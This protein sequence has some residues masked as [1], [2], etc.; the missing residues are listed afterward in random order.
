MCTFG[1]SYCNHH[2]QSIL[3]FLLGLDYTTQNFPG[4]SDLF[5]SSQ[6]QPHW[7]YGCT[8]VHKILRAVEHQI[9]VRERKKKSNVKLSSAFV[10]KWY[11]LEMWF[12]G[13]WGNRQC[14]LK[15]FEALEMQPMGLTTKILVTS[16]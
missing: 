5:H 3:I 11:G 16:T 2:Q 15:C 1:P 6:K 8:R 13:W 10:F 4:P 9:P 7:W 14:I 12:S